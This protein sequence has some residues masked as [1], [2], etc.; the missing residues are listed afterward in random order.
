MDTQPITDLFCCTYARDAKWVEYM[1][2]SVRKYARE[3]RDTIVMYPNHEKPTFAPMEQRFP[4]VRWIG[5]NE[6]PDGHMHQNL[7][8]CTADLY[9]DADFICHIDS[10]CMFTEKSVPSD[11]FTNGKPDLLFNKYSDLKGVPWQGITEAAL[12][13]ACPNETMR[14]FPF[15]YPR[16]LYAELRKHIE[17]LHNKPFSEYVF[18]APCI[19]GAFH[20]FSEFESLGSLAINSFSEFFHLYDMANGAKHQQVRQ[21]WSWSGLTPQE[22]FDLEWLTKE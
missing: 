1:L 12:G 9:S 7:I 18:T 2:R 6:N 21:Y 5:F 16:W 10:D 15:V 3:F 22:R 14:R 8:K 4:W 11:F 17:T 19:K 13:F 20:G